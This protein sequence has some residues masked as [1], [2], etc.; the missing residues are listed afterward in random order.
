[1][2]LTE[3]ALVLHPVTE[4]GGPAPEGD[5]QDDFGSSWYVWSGDRWRAS[6]KP[7]F[8]WGY[9]EETAAGL[10][11]QLDRVMAAAIPELRARLAAAEAAAGRLRE[12]TRSC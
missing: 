9:S 10:R 12:G 1:V 5:L 8:Y 4:E 3:R 11:E 6:A 7:V 2:E